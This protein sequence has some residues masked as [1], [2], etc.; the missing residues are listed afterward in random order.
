VVDQFTIQNEPVASI[1]LMERAAQACV[2]QLV[3]YY[4]Q[5]FSC[6]IICGPGNNGGDGLAIARLLSALHYNIQ[7]LVVGDDDN[8]SP[9]RQT[10]LERWKRAGGK[11]LHEFSEAAPFHIVIDALFGAGLNR[12]PEGVFATLIHQINATRVPVVAID[13]PSGLFC[14][15]NENND[16]QSVIRAAHTFTF[17]CPK[18]TQLL[19]E[20]GEFVGQLHILDI[21]LHPAILNNT[22]T[23]YYFTTAEDVKQI[24]LT[25]SRFAHKGTC[26]HA[27]VMAGSAGMSGAALLASRATLKVEETISSEIDFVK[28]DV[29]AI[30]PGIGI[31]QVAAQSLKHAIVNSGLPLVIDADAINILAEHKMWL[32]YLPGECVLT[33]H[34]G[35]FDRL[36]GT[37]E[38]TEARLRTL[39]MKCLTHRCV[40]VLKGAYAAVGL[41]NG[42]IC[43]NSSGNAGMATA[44]SGDVLTGIIAGLIA[45]GYTAKNAA[46]AGVY[47]H[48]LAGD[49]VASV[50]AEESLIASDIM[51]HLGAAIRFVREH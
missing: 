24:L 38:N 31:S 22:A 29:V 27:L 16:L 15:T 48:G 19:P 40:I 12:V 28:Y 49:I 39:R 34:P 4:D 50:S 45:Q 6:L 47:L 17:Q 21:G 5:R 35:E 13:I 46:L 32:E 3:K 43:F 42:T 14:D 18:L 10:N 2:E 44:G 37:H 8:A 25:R 11:V 36:F 9:D 30:G 1:D 23:E 41:P 20:S 26:G 33:P 7:V 51:E